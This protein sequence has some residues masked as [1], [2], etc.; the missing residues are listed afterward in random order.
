[1]SWDHPTGWAA[2]LRQGYA[3]PRGTPPTLP[4]HPPQQGCWCLVGSM[5]GVG[6]P[7]ALR[8]S[9][10]TGPGVPPPPGDVRPAKAGNR[11]VPRPPI[12][13]PMAGYPIVWHRDTRRPHPPYWNLLPS[14]E[15]C[16]HHTHPG[17]HAGTRGVCGYEEGTRPTGSLD[18]W[19]PERASCWYQPPWRYPASHHPWDAMYRMAGPTQREWYQW[20]NPWGACTP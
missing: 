3:R 10:G 4:C 13:R 20:H 15:D 5:Y 12:P 1:V 17:R 8:C 2:P 18:Q 9:V 11:W 6:L 7:G 16:T 14:Q 19:A